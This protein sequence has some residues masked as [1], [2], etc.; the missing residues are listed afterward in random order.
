MYRII[1]SKDYREYGKKYNLSIQGAYPILWEI[2]PSQD[3]TAEILPSFLKF[4]SKI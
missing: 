4:L 3:K 2:R 1:L